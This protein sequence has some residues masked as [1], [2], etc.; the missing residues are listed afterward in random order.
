MGLKDTIQ[1]AYNAIKGNNTDTD[2]VERHMGFLSSDDIDEDTLSDEEQLLASLGPEIRERLLENA[3]KG[4]NNGS[5]ELLPPRVIPVHFYTDTPT[6]SQVLA[7]LG[8]VRWCMEKCASA[9][10]ERTYDIKLTV[11]NRGKSPFLVD[12]GNKDIMAV[13][14]TTDYK[15]GN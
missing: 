11:S 14:V 13:P 1:K 10:D 6:A 4:Q 7:L 2:D 8:M 3:R 9:D 15:I 12:M 5:G